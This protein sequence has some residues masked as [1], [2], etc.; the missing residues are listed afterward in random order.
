MVL[1]VIRSKKY[2]VLFKWVTRVRGKLKRRMSAWLVGRLMCMNKRVLVEGSLVGIWVGRLKGRKLGGLELGGLELGGRKLGGL[3]LGGLEL[4]GL[5]GGR[6]AIA[7]M[8]EGRFT[9]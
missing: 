3:E 2:G 6:L 7:L 9:Q 4:G 5:E 8:L 1:C